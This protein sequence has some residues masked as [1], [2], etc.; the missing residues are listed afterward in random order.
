MRIT[1]LATDSVLNNYGCFYA[2]NNE[3]TWYPFAREVTIEDIYAVRF[4]HIGINGEMT[5]G[6]AEGESDIGRVLDTEMIHLLN[7]DDTVY[8]DLVNAQPVEPV[9]KVRN[10]NAVI[11]TLIAAKEVAESERCL[12]NAYEGEQRFAN[13]PIYLEDA[14]DIKFIS[15]SPDYPIKVGRTEGGA[16]I[17]TAANAEIIYTTSGEETIYISLGRA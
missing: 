10:E 11:T 16:E 4:K 6:Y 8:V 15:T 3:E 14:R 12:F 9:E 1:I 13:E 5:V 2:I 7:G 17:G